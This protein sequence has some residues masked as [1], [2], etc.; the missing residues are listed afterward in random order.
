MK[1]AHTDLKV[2]CWLSNLIGID[3]SSNGVDLGQALFDARQNLAFD[4]HTI[5]HQVFERIDTFLLEELQVLSSNQII[6]NSEQTHK[7]N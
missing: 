2:L 5:D 4:F 6:I 1:N 7:V 3:R